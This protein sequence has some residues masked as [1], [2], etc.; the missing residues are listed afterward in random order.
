M[1][2]N[3]KSGVI[4]NNTF[5]KDLMNG[6]N[7]STELTSGQYI[8]FLGEIMDDKKKYYITRYDIMN[9]NAIGVLGNEIVFYEKLEK[10]KT[11]VLNDEITRFKPITNTIYDKLEKGR[12]LTVTSFIVLNDKRYYRTKYNTEYDMNVVL[13][14]EE[15]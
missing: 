10:E 13:D 5:K 12:V 15:D 8:Q 2:D 3:A 4:L 7:S 6:Y 11:I 9:D 14:I 1:Y